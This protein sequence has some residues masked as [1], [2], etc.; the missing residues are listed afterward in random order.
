MDWNFLHLWSFLG[1][2]IVPTSISVIAVLLTVLASKG[3]I[4]GI[5]GNY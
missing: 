5:R 3:I 4:V 2:V 1:N